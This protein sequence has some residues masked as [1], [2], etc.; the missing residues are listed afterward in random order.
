MINK[1]KTGK[2]LIFL[3]ALMVSFLL[4]GT[5]SAG[6]PDPV[7]QDL[8]E[9]GKKVY[10]KRCVWCHGVEGGGDGPSADRLFTRPR[11]FIPGTFK[12]RVTDSGQL[13]TDN[14]LIKTVKNGLP[15]SAMPAWGEFLKE[16]EIQAVVQFVKSLVQDRD[17]ND[18]E[19]EEVEL[20]EFGSNP[21]GTTGPYHIGIPQEAIDAGKEIFTKNK[22]FECH[23]G[24][25]RG[26][27][28]PTMKDDWGFPILA[29]DW[30]QCW[31][32]R[33]SRR[34]HFD[35]FNV[36]RTISTGLNGT[37]MPNFR[38]KITVEDRWKLAAFV[39]SLCP[40]K[41]ID[42]LTSKPI[43][44]F[45]ISSV[46]TEGDIVEKIDD[47]MWQSSDNDPLIIARSEEKAAN[48]RRN[49]IALAGQITRGKRNFDPKVDNLWVSSRW[50][51]DKGVYYLVEY[52]LRFLSSDAGFP[53]AVAIQWPA[54]LQDLFGAEKPYFIMGD[55][56]KPVDVWRASFMPKDYNSTN[57]PKEEGYQLDV[58]VDEFNGRGF[59]ALEP[60]E[61]E[62]TVKVVDSIFHQ[63]RVKILFHRALT[64][65]GEMDVQIPPE[66]FI[67]IS[68][69]QWAGDDKE[70]DEHMAISTWY[71]TI[72]EPPLPDSLYYMPPIMAVVFVGLQG[73]LVWMT[74]RTRK[75]YADGKVKRDDLPF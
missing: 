58:T 62:P 52:H 13:P 45:L 68:F 74:K 38:E 30:Q 72:L 63:G 50:N 56:K 44:D 47:P 26:D 54:K 46:Y 31:N 15:G 20:M 7:K 25:G 40:R 55:S 65:D 8:L 48:P 60:K 12:I 19:D 18:E 17:F 59:D 6:I 37:P 21:W 5:A 29:A 41:K 43:P 2:K 23:G 69:F 34:N 36:V 39:N 53:D 73:W 10:F 16:D 61:T 42:K 57:A 11:N 66:Q 71:Y 33:G 27:G 64:T 4:V 49:Y 70:K 28:N 75:M 51:K 67:P 22:C 9:K 14:D 1:M 35:P 32:F 3:L 24:E